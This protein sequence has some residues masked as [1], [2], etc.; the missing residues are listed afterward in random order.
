MIALTSPPLR[1]R[2]EDIP[3]LTEHFVD[4]YCAKNTKNHLAVERDALQQLVAYDWPGN[5]RE[6]QN[7]IERAVV[8]NKSGVIKLAD[9][10]DPVARAEPAARR[11]HLPGGNAAQRGRAARDSRHAEAH[12]RGQTTRRA[13]PRNFAA[14]DLSQARRREGRGRPLNGRAPSE[15][16]FVNWGGSS[17]P[18][19]P[20]GLRLSLGY[21]P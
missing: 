5:V 10:P 20:R 16:H 14:Y 13:T 1:A 15:C 4:T 3:L 7:V 8:L 12:I 19:C 6:L 11:V 21:G 2:R 17:P 18:R 9:L